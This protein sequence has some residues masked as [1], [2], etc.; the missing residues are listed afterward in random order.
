M[1]SKI[2]LD[3]A[4]EAVRKIL[5]FY[6][7]IP[8]SNPKAF[9]AGLVELLLMYDRVVVERATSAA[10]GI[11]AELNRWNLNL[12]DAKKLLDGWQ[13]EENRRVKYK[14][15]PKPEVK[16]VDEETRKKIGEKMRQLADRLRNGPSAA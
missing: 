6:E 15:L 11:P 14:P 4:V 10:M 2:S 9:S 12:A 7:T 5:N 8:A 13:A 1:T 16:P 3:E